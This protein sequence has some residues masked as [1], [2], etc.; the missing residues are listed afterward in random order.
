MKVTAKGERYKLFAV[1]RREIYMCSRGRRPMVLEKH[2][3]AWNSL[4]EVEQLWL[5]ATYQNNARSTQSQ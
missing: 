4:L 3:A 2:S 1:A 5:Q